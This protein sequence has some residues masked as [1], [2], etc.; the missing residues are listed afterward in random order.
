VF[1]RI[2]VP[3]DGSA[4]SE[5]ALPFALSIADRSKAS[6]EIALV[7]VPAAYSEEYP[8]PD[9]DSETSAVEN[10]YLDDLAARLAK[11]FHGDLQIRHLEGIVQETLTEEVAQQDIDLV[12]L[13][14][15]GW[16][17]MSRAIM[18]SVSDYLMRHLS[19]PLLLM[20]SQTAIHDLTASRAFCHILTCLDGSKMAE[21]VLG[22]ARALGRLWHSEH[23]LLRVVS[24]PYQLAEDKPKAPRCDQFVP[25]ASAAE[26]YLERVAQQMRNEARVETHVSVARNVASTIAQYAAT[27]DCDLIAI[28]THGRGGLS[29]LLLGSVAD[30]V[31]RG[32]ATP[33]LV[34]RGEG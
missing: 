1:R 13:N 12:A 34:F 17:Y 24:P 26:S 14:A 21:S 22:P 2:L 33:V 29:R 10:R 19:V 27:H 9:L 16:G 6:V 32:A 30:K 25:A 11:S 20:H 4:L 8:S 7:H 28:S 3:L 15:H 23:S 18:G 31:V 5:Y